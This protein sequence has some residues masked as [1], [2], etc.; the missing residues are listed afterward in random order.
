MPRLPT[1]VLA[2]LA[3]A[4]A[5]QES[6]APNEPSADE[7]AVQSFGLA[8]DTASLCRLIAPPPADEATREAVLSAIE[9]LSDPD[10]DVREESARRLLLMGPTILPLLEESRDVPDLEASDRILQILE[11]LSGD[12]YRTAVESALRLLAARRA[13]VAVD[14]LLEFLDRTADDSLAPLAVIA[15]RTSVDAGSLPRVV[16]WADS[17][18]RPAARRASVVRVLGESALEAVREEL[19]AMLEDPAPEVR[20]EA[21]SALFAAG[22]AAAA[23]ALLDLLEPAHAVEIRYRA[24]Y[25]LRR[26]L[27]PGFDYNAYGPSDDR[28]KSIERWRRWWTE[29]GAAGA[30]PDRPEVGPEQGVTTIV[31]HSGNRIIEVDREGKILW[32]IGDI[33]GPCRAEWLPNGNLLVGGGYSERLFEVGRDKKEVWAAP[34]QTMYVDCDRL[35]NG[36]TLVTSYTERFVAELDREGRKVWTYAGPGIRSLTDADRLANGN[37]L[38]CDYAASRLFEV[39]PAG[40]VVWE[41]ATLAAPYEADRLPNGNTIVAESSGGRVS[42]IDRDGK[43]VWKYEGLVGSHHVD[44]LPSGNTLICDS[45]GDRVLEVTPEGKVVWEFTDVNHPDDADRR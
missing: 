30:R 15:L 12:A 4:A 16:E 41:L 39:S 28:A 23:P 36:N 42:E 21:A 14:P 17:R 19:S 13:A 32:E 20:L 34:L 44:R 9:G 1:L 6:P 8:S 29:E 27:G 2:L 7:K 18:D 11:T 25:A 40:E 38:I 10:Y 24:E 45:E 5:A 43:V 35:D 37:T 33:R 31:D 26:V 22:E 3:A